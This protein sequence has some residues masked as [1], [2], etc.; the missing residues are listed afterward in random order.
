M[1]LDHIYTRKH[2]VV[3]LIALTII[4][5]LILFTFFIAQD[6]YEDS[7][8]VDPKVDALIIGSKEFEIERATTPEQR[9]QGLS[10]RQSLAANTGLLFEF[11]SEGEH[12]IWMKDMLFS[13]DIIWIDSAKSIVH[14]EEDISPD[15][16]P[17]TFTNPV[18]AL[19]V[20]EI[21]AGDVNRLN[22]ELGDEVVFG[23]GATLDIS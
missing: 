14:I 10:G 23:L 2:V 7:K 18:P 5:V 13:I 20:F 6:T 21:N 1:A 11:D 17:T 9:V 22:I 4:L 19:Y 16:Y 8:K 12:G 15:T 3:G